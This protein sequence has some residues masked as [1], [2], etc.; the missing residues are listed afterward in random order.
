MFSACAKRPTSSKNLFA[1]EIQGG[2]QSFP[3]CRK[4]P[5][6]SM[7]FGVIATTGRCPAGSSWRKQNGPKLR[8]QKSLSRGACEVFP[9][10]GMMQSAGACRK[11]L[12][13]TGQETQLLRLHGSTW[14]GNLENSTSLR[15][16]NTDETGKDQRHH[17]NK[18][19]GRTSR[20]Q[21]CCCGHTACMSRSFSQ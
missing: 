4:N 18:S 16:F 19:G 10:G 5:L 3:Q 15:I 20:S 9:V 1:K 21:H 2:R 8:N 12:A 7:L 13:P 14:S 11:H 6:L 17:G